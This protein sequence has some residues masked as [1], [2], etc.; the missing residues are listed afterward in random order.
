MKQFAGIATIAIMAHAG[1][2]WAQPVIVAP[3]DGPVRVERPP[4]EAPGRALDPDRAPTQRTESP[5]IE[6]RDIQPSQDPQRGPTQRRDRDQAQRERPDQAPSPRAQQ[7]QRRD[8]QLQ[9][10]QAQRERQDDRN[11]RRSS[12]QAQPENRT[13]QS[14]ETAQPQR[15]EGRPSTPSTAQSAP[16]QD[17]QQRPATNAQRPVTTQPG[18]TIQQPAQNR[19]LPSGQNSDNAQV[20][21]GDNQRI[22]DTVRQRVERNEVRPVQNLGVSVSVGAELPSRV[23][24]QPLP[25]DIAAIRPQYRDYRY[26]VSERDIVIVDPRSR[27]IVEVIDRGGGGRGGSVDIYAAFERRRDV[28]RWNRPDTVVFRQGAILPVGVP[29][30]DLPDEVIARHPDWRGYQYVM[31]ESEEVAVVE[32]RTRRIVDV[33]DKNAPRSAAA[34]PADARAAASPAASNGTT[35]R[36]ELARMILADARPGEIQGVDGLKGAVLPTQVVLRPLP[37]EVEQ[38]DQQLRGLHYALIGDDVLIVDPKS[39]EIVVVIE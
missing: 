32:P 17:D 2:A 36:H 27:R 23:Q 19:A 12:D 5:A 9:R 3:G 11:G 30:Y 22:A 26:T 20:G 4:R 37:P 6:R 29:Y 38:Q 21:A 8:E 13:P 10:D 31:T 28:R 7:E 14:P 1:V 18:G 24:L 33:V 39:R 16:K 15:P 35:D 25:S 34:A